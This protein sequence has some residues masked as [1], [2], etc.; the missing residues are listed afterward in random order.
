[1]PLDNTVT[2]WPNGVN[3][4]ADN[5]ILANYRGLNPLRYQTYFDD[6]NFYIP[7][8]WTVTETQAGATQG[9]QT[10]TAG[11]WLAL[12]NSAADDDLNQ[13]QQPATTFAFTSAK[14]LII[15]TTLSLSD[16]TQSDAIIGLYVLDT[17]PIASLPA[18]GI[19]FLKTDGAATLDFHLR[20]AGTSTTLASVATL[21]D[22]T[23]VTLSAVY[24]ALAQQWTI[25]VN[26]SY[27]AST[28]TLTNAPS[29]PLSIGIAV[30]NG[31]AVAK[32]LLSDYFFAAVQR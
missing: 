18:N 24:Q 22:A 16:A 13:I 19:F 27:A 10:A 28:T 21:A 31:E 11:G 4:T 5:A 26:G 32:T 29:V 23:N 8:Q 14:D 30:Q 3:D 1:M 17:T 25:Y 9:I 12:V 15:Q 6:F 7:T 2:R 20:A